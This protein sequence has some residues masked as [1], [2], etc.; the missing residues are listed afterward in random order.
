MTPLV[1]VIVT[2]YNQAPYIEETLRSVLAQTYEHREVIVVDDGSTDDTPARLARFDASIRCI[3]QRN[4]GVAGSR[5]TGVQHARGQLVA[6]LDGDDLW[7]PE[8][9]AIQV[10]AFEAHP[11]SG[12]IAVDAAEFCGSGIL[13]S[14]T[15]PWQK[16]FLRAN[17]GGLATVRCHRELLY[18][19]FIGTTSQVMVPARV[20][21]AVG[22]SDTRFNVSSDYDLYI[23]IAAR[24]EFTFVNEVL[25]RRRY[26][27][28]S[29]SGPAQRRP[30]VWGQDVIEILKKHLR[31]NSHEGRELIKSILPQRILATAEAAYYY[32]SDQDR[33]WATRYLLRLAA[34]NPGAL[35]PCLFLAGL[36]T[37]RAVRAAV[38]PF[39]RKMLPVELVA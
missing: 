10:H 33:A 36:W 3:R 14:S 29:A 30:L 38:R 35:G 5:N 18:G 11:A 4:Q 22:L 27:E 34:R 23:R 25:V 32:G 26:L 28:T 9:L 15:L 39:V 24:H 6:F 13:R 16:S 12:L 31:D 21:R 19:N 7:E 20:I 17:Q 1:S 2:T 8:K 37:P